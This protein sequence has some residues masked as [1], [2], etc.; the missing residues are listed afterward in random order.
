MR[1]IIVIQQKPENDWHRRCLPGSNWCRWNLT[2]CMGR[3]IQAAGCKNAIRSSVS[4]SN[5]WQI[6]IPYSIWKANTLFKNPMT[7]ET[8]LNEAASFKN[9]SFWR[10]NWTLMVGWQ[11]SKKRLIGILAG[12]PTDYH[13]DLVRITF[14]SFQLKTCHHSCF[15][16]EPVSNVF[17]FARWDDNNNLSHV[18]IRLMHC[19][20]VHV[21][22]VSFQLLTMTLS[23]AVI[24]QWSFFT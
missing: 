22:F 3:V 8:W 18:I 5:N 6:K 14:V 7:F 19:Y 9:W 11:T 12:L 23:L 2:L 13:R 1:W 16:N 17:Y 20:L 4:N 21:I 15:L 10:K 24:S